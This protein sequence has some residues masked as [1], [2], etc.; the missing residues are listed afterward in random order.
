M[1][2]FSNDTHCLN[3]TKEHEK[4]NKY[5]YINQ[6]KLINVYNNI[7]RKLCNNL[8]LFVFVFLH[9]ININ[10]I[11]ISTIPVKSLQNSIFFCYGSFCLLFVWC[12]FHF[13]LMSGHERHWLLLIPGSRFWYFR[14][15]PQTEHIQRRST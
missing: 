3:I 15:V 5:I 4:N 10:S 6:L 7:Y 12:K 2:Q 14:H 11:T 9:R 1:Y 8:N 13:L